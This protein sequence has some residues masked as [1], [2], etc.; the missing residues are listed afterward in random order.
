MDRNTLNIK[1]KLLALLCSI[2]TVYLIKDKLSII[3]LTLLA[4]LYLGVQK[5]WKCIMSAGSFFL[6]IGILLVLI[7]F[8]SIRIIIFPEFYILFFWTLYPVFLVSW[9]LIT[10]P[11]GEISAFLSKVHIPKI[12][13]LGVLVI[14]RFFP[15][16]KSELKNVGQSMKNR[17]L[18][19]F[20]KVFVH[21][22]V[23]CEY[24]LVPML[25]KCIQAADQLSISAIVRGAESPNIRGSYYY[26]KI[27]YV[28][29]IWMFIWIISSVILVGGF[30][31]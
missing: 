21:P 29:Y 6:F 2:M 20:K 16:V 25:L 8:Y 28:D 10:T 14:F 22:V 4:F 19:G 5:K 31:V 24:V 17:N 26:R 12:I 18:L 23:T 1:V 27:N 30:I 15:T 3:Y 9:D 13:I 11:P 7:R